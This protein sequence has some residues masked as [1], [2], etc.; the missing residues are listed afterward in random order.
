ME[1]FVMWCVSGKA[2]EVDSRW[3]RIRV[4]CPNNTYRTLAV[5]KGSPNRREH[6]VW[7]AMNQSPLTRCEFQYWST[8]VQ[9]RVGSA[10]HDIAMDILLQPPHHNALTACQYIMFVLLSYMQR[11]FLRCFH[12]FARIMVAL[13][14]TVASDPVSLWRIYLFCD[15]VALRIELC[16][17]GTCRSTIIGRRIRHIF[18]VCL[19]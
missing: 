5:Q 19:G 4:M 13:C 8:T 17:Y 11:E 6:N 1:V 14:H 10:R 15:R 12:T 7:S 3:V 2:D 9:E 16:P 18:P